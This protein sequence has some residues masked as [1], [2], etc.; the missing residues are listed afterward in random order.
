MEPKTL[1]QIRGAKDLVEETIDAAALAINEVQ[2]TMTR[3]PYALLAR[4]EP[5][6]APVQAIEQVHLKIADSVYFSIRVG[7]RL[8]GNVAGFMLDQ[9]DAHA[10]RKGRS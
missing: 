4:I 6:A 9:L 5:I 7:N 10:Q 8:V 2:R 3:M 1:R